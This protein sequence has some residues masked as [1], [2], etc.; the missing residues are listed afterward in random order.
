MDFRGKVVVQIRE[1]LYS[2]FGLVEIS[3]FPLHALLQHLLVHALVE[4]QVRA[5][6]RLHNS[7]IQSFQE[8]L[9]L[10]Y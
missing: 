6:L 5:V 10:L 2:V 9:L 7:I 3:R 1:V 4:H 8:N